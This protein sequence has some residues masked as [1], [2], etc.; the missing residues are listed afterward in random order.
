MTAF[1]WLC[2]A[3]F[4]CQALTSCVQISS[5]QRDTAGV[6]AL[7]TVLLVSEVCFAFA[8]ASLLRS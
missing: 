7:R 3:W 4:I 6:R 5:I 8:A 2:L 1:L